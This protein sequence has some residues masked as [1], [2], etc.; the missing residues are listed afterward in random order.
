[1]DKL[2]FD[3]AKKIWTEIAQY[4]TPGELKLEV[5][6][7][8]KMLNIFQVGDY[9]YMVFNPP[10]MLFEY[11]SPGVITMLGY[12]PDKFTLDFF[13]SSI[14]PDDLPYFMDFEAEV[15][16]FFTS[17]PAEKVMKYK[18][19]YDYRLRRKDGS[20]M[21][22]HQQ[23]V[24]IQTDE[25][26]AVLRTFVVHTDISHLKSTNKMSL[27]FI[28]LEGEP[29]YINVQLKKKFI[30][31]REVLSRREKDILI[32]LSQHK[33]SAEIA[34]ILSISPRTVSTHRKNM[35]AKTGASTVLQLV[36][37]AM[38]KGWL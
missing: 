21:R 15:T 33:S 28:G 6:L 5:E 25:N 2:I 23:V 17:L 18:T 32:L 11:V 30:A 10:E 19:R 9:Y 34:E 36:M 20:Y 29:S 37:M 1:M 13:V 8:K 26:G 35:H 38:E 22:V 7:Y 4:K 24:T 14:H 31:A 27:S 16:R 12:E 3:E